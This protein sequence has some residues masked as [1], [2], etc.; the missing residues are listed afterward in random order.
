M[1]FWGNLS[2]AAATLLVVSSIPAKAETW[3]VPG[4]YT[5]KVDGWTR[6]A[7]PD[8][9]NYRCLKCTDQIEIE[10]MYGPLFSPDALW[11]TN[12]E[13]IA[14]LSTEDRRQ[15]FADAIMTGAV[16]PGSGFKVEVK[17]VGLDQLGG[18]R[19]LMMASEVTMGTTSTMDTSMIA[20]HKNRLVRVTVHFFR[21][22]L[23]AE[24]GNAINAF[25]DGLVFE[26]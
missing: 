16:P 18:L 8:G 20:V 3:T 15:T 25:M 9:F 13:F 2:S 11:K 23:T 6:N 21:G 4:M 7:I 24:S 10:V 17:K 14:A 12:D 1:G 22:A 5:V 19:V 26:K